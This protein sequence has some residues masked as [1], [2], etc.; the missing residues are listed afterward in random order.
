MV[1]RQVT[2][3]DIRLKR[4]EEETLASGRK[5]LRCIFESQYGGG[6]YIWIP[7]WREKPGQHGVEKLFFKAL[8]V[9]E[10]NDP[11]GAW[12]EELEK[13]SEEVPKL[14]EFRLP[15]RI[16]CTGLVKVPADKWAYRIVIS[17][18]GEEATAE[19]LRSGNLRIGECELDFQQFRQD[20]ETH[21]V[22]K[23]HFSLSKDL[24]GIWEGSGW[25]AYPLGV[26]FSVF[27]PTSVKTENYRLLGY[28]LSFF[29]RSYIRRELQR[30]YYL[31][32]G[33]A[34]SP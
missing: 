8:E 4:F 20:F 2:G 12:Y 11:Q 9:E 32:N 26:S 23:W 29:L 25:G 21:F 27:V 17:I 28:E 15:V 18:F 10:W 34:E 30:F 33:F 6:T 31:K 7:P 13:V 16:D 1:I 24:D 5:L 3:K 22:D 19:R 14:R